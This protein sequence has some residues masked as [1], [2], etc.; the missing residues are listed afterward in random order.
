MIWCDLPRE[1]QNIKWFISHCVAP[2]SPS[3]F[4]IQKE[5]GVTPQ[6]EIRWR[7]QI[8]WTVVSISHFD[9]GMGCDPLPPL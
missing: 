2:P 1:T 3:L 5:G 7:N 4:I 6:N 9:F 8:T